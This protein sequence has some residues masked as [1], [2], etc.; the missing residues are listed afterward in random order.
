MEIRGAEIDVKAI[1]TGMVESTDAN[2]FTE[3]DTSLV[4]AVS[5]VASPS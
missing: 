2:M 5:L 4:L 1:L 3:L